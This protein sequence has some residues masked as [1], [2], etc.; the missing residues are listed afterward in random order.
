MGMNKYAVLIMC[1]VGM[2]LLSVFF[3]NRPISFAVTASPSETL[4]GAGAKWAANGGT[5]VAYIDWYDNLV[6]NPN[7]GNAGSDLPLKN[8]VLSV[9]QGEGFTINT[10]GEIP[11]NL[12]QYSLVYLEAYFACN[13]ANASLIS[14]YISSGGGV[15]IYAGAICY[16][17]YASKTMNTGEDLSSVASWF[18]ASYY[19]NTGGSA[20][21]TIPDPLGTTLNVG[22]TLQTVT[23]YS[24]AGV[25]DMNQSSMV[26]GTWND[27][28]TFAFTNTYGQGRVY[29]Q[30][31]VEPQSTQ[32]PTSSGQLSLMLYG[33]FDYGNSE[34][35]Q[36]KVL[37]ELR[38]PI[39]MQPIS[40]ATVN[41]QVFY[42]NDT[43][44]VSAPM[45]EISSGT[46][47]Y[48]WESAGTIAN[49]NLPMGVY[50]AQV[51][52]S[53]GTFSASEIIA[54]HI[55]PPAASTVS[56][57]I[58]MLQLCIVTILP[59]L[60]SGTFIAIAFVFFKKRQQISACSKL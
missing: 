49:M 7:L 59:L 20:V 1:L 58:G 23:G 28:S 12:S 57:G 39:T 36:V 34:Q 17:A 4:L 60:F 44:W 41:I 2:L 38:D 31:R 9:L 35:A 30:A 56:T 26:L 11:A 22:D 42:P 43:S 14:N 8:E 51:T 52:A 50:Y 19:D 47:I 32:V 29:W 15:V 54:F 10:F 13:P 5:K 25:I 48:E 33:A 37:A 45:V 6:A 46:G 24:C 53:N 18:G 27:G 3:A 55:D 16:L 21:V 40:G